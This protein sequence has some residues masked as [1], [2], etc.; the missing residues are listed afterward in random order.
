SAWSSPGQGAHVA[1]AAA[2]L[3]HGQ[4]EAGSLCPLT[5]TSAAIPVIQG[6]SWFDSLAPL[7]YGAQYDE[8][9]A[10]LSGKTAMLIGMGMTEKQGGSDLRSNRTH[11]VA[12]GQEGRGALY[13][14]TGHKW[15]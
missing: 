1:R 5:M 9:D 13:R 15:F 4:V 7:L 14:L 12:L 11:A 2:Y 8:H 10:P 6:E 3:M